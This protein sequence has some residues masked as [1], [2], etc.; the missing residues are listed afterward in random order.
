[1]RTSF[2]LSALLACLFEIQCAGTPAIGAAG[3]ND[4]NRTLF[5][6]KDWEITIASA[7]YATVTNIGFQKA[8]IAL[9]GKEKTD[10]V[11]IVLK[12]V[13]LREADLG[14]AVWQVT[15]IP[16]VRVIDGS[17]LERA[18]IAITRENMVPLGTNWDLYISTTTPQSVLVQAPGVKLKKGDSLDVLIGLNASRELTQAIT[19][20]TRL[21]ISFEQGSTVKIPFPII[22]SAVE[23][24]ISIKQAIGGS[25]PAVAT[26]EPVWAKIILDDELWNRKAPWPILEALGQAAAQ[27]TGGANDTTDELGLQEGVSGAKLTISRLTS[28]YGEGVK[29]T[30]TRNDRRITYYRYGPL[31]LGI[32]NG[33]EFVDWVVAPVDFYKNGFTARARDAIGTVVS[34]TQAELTLA[35][36]VGTWRYSSAFMD[37]TGEQWVFAA[38]GEV[39][40]GK[41]KWKMVG[42][43]AIADGLTEFRV[44]K[45]RD[46]FLSLR[47]HTPYG[48]EVRLVRGNDTP[49]TEFTGTWRDSEGHMSLIIGDLKPGNYNAQLNI[50]GYGKASTSGTSLDRTP[51]G[52][53][54]NVGSKDWLLKKV[55]ANEMTASPTLSGSE[56]ESGVFKTII[57][58]LQGPS[59]TSGKAGDLR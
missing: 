16:E 10:S 5:R 50:S 14:S 33:S 38:D 54:V 18:G 19:P 57:L 55:G 13:A 9:K 8:T 47:G 39:S 29:T 25:A 7:Q 52:F 44:H 49:V 35:D 6:G 30:G 48:D 21:S 37:K 59:A 4:T 42:D 56:G 1:M 36:I 43:R 20:D 31:A 34:Q 58:K 3:T 40:C 22:V 53:T 45:I 27:L 26:N 23:N 2:A 17:R 51:E 15:E 24:N 12:C 11:A 32:Q 41:Q 28:R 46:N